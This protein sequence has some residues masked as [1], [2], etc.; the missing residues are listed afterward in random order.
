M[1]QDPSKDPPHRQPGPRSCT[2]ELEQAKELN[3][4]A[5]PWEE[6]EARP[7]FPEG[8]D[9]RKRVG[10]AAGRRGAGGSLQQVPVAPRLP[11]S[12]VS[13]QGC[14]SM[15]LE[16]GIPQPSLARESLG[17]EGV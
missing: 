4:F 13:G 8:T 5:R 9:G 11:F 14:C 17:M 6:P 12:L 16:T 1:S 2:K 15:G 7:A 3:W 10:R